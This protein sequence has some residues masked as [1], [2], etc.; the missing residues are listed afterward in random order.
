MLPVGRV[1]LIGVLVTQQLPVE[2]PAWAAVAGLLAVAVVAVVTAAGVV[3]EVA[4]VFACRRVQAKSPSYALHW[5]P[6]HC[7][8]CH[9]G[10]VGGAKEHHLEPY[11]RLR[12]TGTGNQTKHPQ[13]LPPSVATNQQNQCRDASVLALCP[14]RI[15]FPRLWLK[16]V[17]GMHLGQGSADEAAEGWHAE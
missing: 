13:R 10:T 12:V 9:L 6:C 7:F 16:G 14:R 15:W 1:A 17:P 11:L 5:A 3:V 4:P 8:G 2:A